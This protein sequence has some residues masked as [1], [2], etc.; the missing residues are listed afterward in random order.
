MKTISENLIDLVY[1]IVI[2]FNFILFLLVANS[3]LEDRVTQCD[4]SQDTVCIY[5]IDQTDNVNLTR[6]DTIIAM[7]M[8]FAEQESQFNNAAVSPY[9]QWVGCLQISK[10]MVEEANRIAGG[11]IFFSGNNGYIDDRFDRQGSYAIFKIV[12][13]HH[14]PNLEINRAIDIWNPRCPAYY[15]QNVRKFYAQNLL[16]NKDLKN[17][18]K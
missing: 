9:G 8:A 13:E 17:Y 4:T 16:Q 3:M 1:V 12:Q 2:L 15:R 5:D 10:I 7:A 6:E 14:N 11:E 18:F